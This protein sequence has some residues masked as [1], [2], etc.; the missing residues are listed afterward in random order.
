MNLDGGISNFIILWD[1]GSSHRYKK[2]P[3][4]SRKKNKKN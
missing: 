4:L 1:G 3:I 2:V